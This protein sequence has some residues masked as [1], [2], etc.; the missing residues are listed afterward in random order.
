[1]NSR[2]GFAVFGLQGIAWLRGVVGGPAAVWR[3]MVMGSAH[4][5]WVWRWAVTPN[6]RAGH[7]SKPENGLVSDE[8]RAVAAGRNALLWGRPLVV[9]C[10]RPMTHCSGPRQ[11][12]LQRWQPLAVKERVPVE[13]E[14]NQWQKKKV[15][16][17]GT[18]ERHRHCTAYN[19]SK[20][21]FQNGQ[22][23]SF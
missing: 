13:P 3:K 7:N 18:Q 5:C 22:R 17:G 6:Q 14:K 8:H 23:V 19:H 9:S 2:G 21:I 15:E 10:R 1:M 16:G 20:P 4:L 12:H 11:S